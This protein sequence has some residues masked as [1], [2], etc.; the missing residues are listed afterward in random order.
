MK[1]TVELEW[2]QI[3]AI[4]KNEIMERIEDCATMLQR[5]KYAHPEDIAYSHKM[6]P[7]LLIVYEYYAGEE[8]VNELR[9]KFNQPPALGVDVVS[10]DDETGDVTLALDAKGKQYLIERG[11]NAM[12]MDALMKLEENEHEREETEGT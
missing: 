7:A 12:L 4:V 11:F 2:E 5:D 10:C 9:E 1:R 8:A 6:L 3:D